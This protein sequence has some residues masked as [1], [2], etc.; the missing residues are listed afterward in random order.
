MWLQS[1]VH[2]FMWRQQA[3]TV[4]TFPALIANFF[5]SCHVF[6]SCSSYVW[7]ALPLVCLILFFRTVAN[8]LW[9]KRFDEKQAAVFAAVM[10]CLA[11]WMQYYPV[12]CPRHTY[13]AIAPMIGVFAYFFW[14]LLKNENAFYR[15]VVSLLAMALLFQADITDRIQEGK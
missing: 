3:S 13:W 6:G 15:S 7:T 8:Y 2:A 4:H 12:L 14:D 1:F 10:V 5:P 9:K 11:S